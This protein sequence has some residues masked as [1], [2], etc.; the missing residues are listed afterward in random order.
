MR[1]RNPLSTGNT[2]LDGALAVGA[3]GAAYYFGYGAAKSS[4]SKTMSS[5][6]IVG[7]VLLKPGSMPEITRSVG[8][9]L[10]FSAPAGG[11]ISAFG[12]STG[13]KQQIPNVQS[14]SVPTEE[15][16]AGDRVVLQIVWFDGAKKPQS[17]QVGLTFV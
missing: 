5:A 1:H 17:S 6:P 3:L 16:A 11:Y 9:P 10:V 8:A 12:T 7:N 4:S 15:G 13:Y 2:W 14:W